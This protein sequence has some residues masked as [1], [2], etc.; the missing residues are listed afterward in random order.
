VN[1]ISHVLVA[2]WVRDR[3]A[4]ILGAMLPDLA[5]ICGGSILELA[6]PDL[7][8]GE[9]HHQEADFVFHCHPRFLELCGQGVQALTGAGLPRPISRA[10]AHVGVE[11]L[12]DA[13]LVEDPDGSLEE[14]Y[15]MALAVGAR[16]Q[17]GPAIR[18]RRREHAGAFEELRGFLHQRGLPRVYLEG[19]FLASVVT[20]ALSRR[21]RL[22]LGQTQ[23]ELVTTWLDQARPEVAAV[24]ADL[25]GS[26]REMLVSS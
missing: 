26:L 4:F 2:S 20:R 15:R 14:R 9:Q 17:L 24:A 25:H 23:V 19:P 11:L 7:E 6:D 5:T 18:W 3:P 21:P 12:L 13:T 8:A 10:V 16:D 1:Y 22:S